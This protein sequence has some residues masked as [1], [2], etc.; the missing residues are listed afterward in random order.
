MSN[1]SEEIY[2]YE[3]LDWIDINKL[4]WNNLSG[5]TKAIN[6]L[7][8]NLDKVSWSYL[9]MNPN[10]INLLQDNLEKIMWGWLSENINAIKLLEQHLDKICWDSLSE[11]KNGIELRP[12]D[13]GL[14]TD[15]AN[16]IGVI[17]EC[18]NIS[19]GYYNEHS[20][21]EIQNIQFDV[22]ITSGKTIGH[23]EFLCTFLELDEN[24]LNITNCSIRV[25]NEIENLF[26]LLQC[27]SN[28]KTLI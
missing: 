12:D 1:S 16:F 26:K 5:N 27:D 23:S 19:V 13:T 4:D 10:A 2:N 22:D 7:K 15:S 25:T 11:N 28:K 8:D 21:S 20:T 3:L 9:S 24:P 18:T 6:L 14:F 17:K